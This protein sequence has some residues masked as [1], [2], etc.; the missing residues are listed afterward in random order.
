[1]SFESDSGSR[2]DESSECQRLL[3]KLRREVSANP[4]DW[5]LSVLNIVAEWP[6]ASESVNGEQF[7]YIVGGEAFNWKRLAERLILNLESSEITNPARSEMWEWLHS[8]HVFGGFEEGL[9]RRTLGIDRWRGHLNY[10]YGVHL[11]QCLFTAIQNRI[12]RRRFA[13]G[14]PLTDDSA[15]EAYEG[16]YY[17]EESVLWQKFL[18]EVVPDNAPIESDDCRSLSLDDEFTYW[19]FKR[20]IDSTHPAQVAYETQRG[21]QMMAEISE[22]DS[23]RLR[24]LMNDETGDLLEFAVI[25]SRRK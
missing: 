2:A 17:D 8:D 24:M 9:F 7:Q 14:M 6:I 11:E 16:L 15:D 21:L 3:L 10:F 23:R 22:A 5:K 4:S 1:M 12:H 18:D 25:G 20:R 19:L 13:R